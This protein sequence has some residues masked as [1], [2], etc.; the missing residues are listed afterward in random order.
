MVKRGIFNK[1]FVG[2]ILAN[3][4]FWMSVNFFLPVLPLYYHGLGLDDH[5]VGIAVGA[6]SLGA[7]SFRLFSGRAVDKY[8]SRPVIT[9]G[10]ALSV[11]AIIAYEYSVT[12]PAATFARFLH[13][14]G[15]SGYSA[16]ALTMV[17]LMYEES[18]VTE[19]VAV[20]TLFTMLGMG[21]AASS[22]NWIFEW[23]GLQAVMAV[24]VICTLISLVLFPAQPMLRTKPA[25]AEAQPLKSAV[26]GRGVIVP[27]F[28][29]LAV[30]LCFGSIMTFMPLFMLS[31][32]MTKFGYFY[33][34][35]SVAVIFSRMMVSRLCNWLTPPRLALYVLLV[36]G[37]T[38]L[39][40]GIW[41][42]EWVLVLCGAGVG[43]GYGLAF[44][45]LATIVTANTR[46]A[47]RGK[48]FGFFTSAVDIG[49]LAGSMGMGLVAAA[50]GYQAVFTAAGVYTLGYAALYRWKLW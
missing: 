26:A 16:A 42:A 17:T 10:I 49:F 8:G 46:P 12:L 35:Y 37:M 24:G 5:Q 50:W 47:D 4:F 18:Q 11:V 1:A 48:A 20:Y 14:I 9:A 27:S 6:F 44:P 30:N 28:S 36:L 23:G 29:L 2:L 7:L 40:A 21:A 32:D 31:R 19:A 22:A 3:M 38:M 45:A 25:A 13:G 34:A 43:V 15:I 33:A 41:G 39:A